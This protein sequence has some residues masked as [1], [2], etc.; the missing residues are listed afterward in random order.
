MWPLMEQM[1]GRRQRRGSDF[2]NQ[3]ELV[4]DFSDDRFTRIG[5]STMFLP[6]C[7]QNPS[8]VTA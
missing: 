1:G 8:S 7:R 6:T 5:T 2:Q 3:G 4:H